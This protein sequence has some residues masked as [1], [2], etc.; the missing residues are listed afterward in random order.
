MHWIEWRG[1]FG[2]AGEVRKGK[3]LRLLLL[4]ANQRR[5]KERIA[6]SLLL[7]I[8]SKVL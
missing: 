8:Y 6:T 7:S 2:V 3:S 4:T 5:Q 1:V